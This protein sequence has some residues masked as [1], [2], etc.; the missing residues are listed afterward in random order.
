MVRALL[1]MAP[2]LPSVLAARLCPINDSD[3]SCNANMQHQGSS[4]MLSVEVSREV[5]SV[6][7]HF[8]LKVPESVPSLLGD[9]PSLISCMLNLI[10]VPDVGSATA[11]MN[12]IEMLL[13]S[14]KNGDG[15]PNWLVAV[16]KADG[17]QV[18]EDLQYNTA[19][20]SLLC[21][22]AAC[23]VDTFYGEDYGIDD[24]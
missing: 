10:T 18:L 2:Q 5:A 6:L 17:I 9:Y 4:E 12:Y 11:G 21:E 22:R 8:G 1:S 23:L 20:P 24:E 13:R 14:S 7:F 3:H 16:E 19:A 15:T